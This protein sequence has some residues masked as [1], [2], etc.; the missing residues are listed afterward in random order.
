MLLDDFWNAQAQSR[1]QADGHNL[2]TVID[3]SARHFCRT[4]LLELNNRAKGNPTLLPQL[5]VKLENLETTKAVDAMVKK[6]VLEMIDSFLRCSG[7]R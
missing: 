2:H 3:L 1:R 5:R 6:E 4:E 7:R